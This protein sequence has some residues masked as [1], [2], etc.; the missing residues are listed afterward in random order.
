MDTEHLWCSFTP[1]LTY[2]EALVLLL[3]LTA[4][5]T[6][7]PRVSHW[8]IS[9]RV[10]IRTQVSLAPGPCPTLSPTLLTET[11]PDSPLGAP[12]GGLA[13]P[14]DYQV[15]VMCVKG[16]KLPIGGYKPQATWNAWFHLQGAQ[17]R[18]KVTG[19]TSPRPCLSFWLD[20]AS[21]CPCS[22]PTSSP[23]FDVQEGLGSCHPLPTLS[24]C[25]LEED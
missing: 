19:T 6:E 2:L 16:R 9:G 3:H 1:P 21:K 17:P 11:V 13:T 23:C 12:I 20:P 18:D 8:L 25:P 22:F 10:G 5:E 24:Q 4:V 14:R 15:G 7:T